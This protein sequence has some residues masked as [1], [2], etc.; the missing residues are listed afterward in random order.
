MDRN[1]TNLVK[2]ICCI[3]IVIHHA[4]LGKTLTTPLGTQA[5]TIFFFLSAYGIAKSLLSNNMGILPFVQKRLSKIY[6]PLLFVNAIF[7]SLTSSAIVNEF[8][9]PTFGILKTI[10]GGG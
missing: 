4:Y 10:E 1:I 7:I 5:C 9:I 8:Y 3:L 2:F 6:M